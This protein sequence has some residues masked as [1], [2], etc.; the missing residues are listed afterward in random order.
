MPEQASDVCWVFFWL[1]VHSEARVDF[2]LQGSNFTALHKGLLT[3]QINEYTT[4]F[5]MSTAHYVVTAIL[6]REQLSFRWDGGPGDV[7]FALDQHS[8]LDFLVP[9]HWNKIPLLD[10]W[11]TSDTSSRYR[12]DQSLLLLIIVAWVVEKQQIL[13]S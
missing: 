12:A 8:Y 13:N 9:T 7:R 11:L 6:L 5:G 4:K 10:V 2:L 1:N 3:S